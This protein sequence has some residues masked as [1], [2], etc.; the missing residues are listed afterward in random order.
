[1][2]LK[3]IGKA[4]T[5]YQKAMEI[6][7]KCQVTSWRHVIEEVMEMRLPSYLVLLSIDS[8]TR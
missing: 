8:K 2:G 1:M 7:P 6:D 5:V 3:D 4:M